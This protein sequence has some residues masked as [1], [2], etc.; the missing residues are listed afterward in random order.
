MIVSIFCKISSQQVQFRSP[1]WNEK[2]SFPRH[3]GNPSHVST[4]SSAIV[5]FGKKNNWFSSL[6][7]LDSAFE[8]QQGMT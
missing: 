2:K 1:A 5:A 8:A 7:V 4:G 3:F 6:A